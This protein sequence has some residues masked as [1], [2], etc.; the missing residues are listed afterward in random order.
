MTNIMNKSTEQTYQDIYRA[1]F[2]KLVTYLQHRYACNLQDAEDIAA[3][4]LHLLWEKW[5]A[6][7]SHTEAGMLRW[8]FLTARNLM[9][10][11]AKKK[12]RR[13]ELIS[14]EEMT[15]SQHP[16]ALPDPTPQQIEEE[17]TRYLTEITQRL[18]PNDAALFRA[19]IAEHESDESIAARLG[20]SVNTLRVRWLR[21]KRR[22]LNI[23]DEL[24]HDT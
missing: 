5:D 17:Y 9:R 16:S 15:D 6:I 18:S 21:V 8:L 20:I 13:P 23:W 24:K 12:R 7:E 2:P 11:E 19:K 14:L 3:R 22:I 1:S 10:D 4:A